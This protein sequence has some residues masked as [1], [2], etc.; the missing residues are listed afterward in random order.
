MRL[1]WT[2]SNTWDHNFSKGA[3]TFT[4]RKILLLQSRL[5]ILLLAIMSLLLPMI[6]EGRPEAIRVVTNTSYPPYSFTDEKGNLQGMEVELLRLRE[7]KTGL[8]S[9][10]CRVNWAQP[11]RWDREM[12][13]TKRKWFGF[14]ITDGLQDYH[15]SYLIGAVVC[16]LL[17][18][19][20][21]NLT[22]RRRVAQ[23]TSALTSQIEHSSQQARELELIFQNSP[24]AIFQST[25][26][27][28]F[29]RVNPAL[30]RMFGYLTPDEVLSS[31]TDIHHQLLV[32]P[33][34]RDE[35]IDGVLAANNFIW[36]EIEYRRKDGTQF[37]GNMCMRAARDRD[38]RLQFFEGFVED[39]TD[40][41]LVYELTTALNMELEQRVEERTLELEKANKALQQ[42]VEF[43]K[44]AQ[45]EI[46]CL[47]AGLVRQRAALEAANNELETFSYSVSHD[48]R[49][50]LRNIIS[51]V[52]ILAEDF[53]PSL[54][55]KAREYLHRMEVS[56]LKMQE[57]IDGLLTLSRLTQG[58]LKAVVLDLSSY[59]REIAQELQQA[60]PQRNVT[61][62]IADRTPA[63][64]DPVLIRSA[65][66]NL[67]RNAW[68]YSSKR[69]H[70]VIEFGCEE[71]DGGH[72]FFVRDNGAGFNMAYADKLFG[73]FQRMHS[74][75]EFEGTGIGLATVQRIIRRHG[76]RIWAESDV[77]KG[78]TFFFTLRTA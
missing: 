57:L 20:I 11:Q 55:E 1:L 68:K 31:V 43:R 59:A 53:G 74:A 39:I 45:V 27:G 64:A 58:E 71:Q 23:R 4:M 21:W 78:A 29:M 41:M 26:E 44:S 6:A 77:D 32:Y 61:L 22:L 47:N 54:E 12:T 9:E 2:C 14:S 13:E 75:S 76:G 35:L 17:L 51:L 42:E 69:E 5:L 8:K 72:V 63:Q 38:G 3:L 50:P 24:I 73:V 46:T 48:L 16:L 19:G 37:L 52:A 67:L 33:E 30:A 10:L 70:S 60:E 40:R 36:R 56:A 28:S 49:A 7:R 66:D 62:V 15:I 25:K 18:L 65:L 34:L